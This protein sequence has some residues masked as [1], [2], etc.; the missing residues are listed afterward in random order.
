M[1]AIARQFG[2]MLN[3]LLSAMVGFRS[4]GLKFLKKVG[5][6]LIPRFYMPASNKQM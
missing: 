3:V 1:E 2:T 4:A 5:L 6:P